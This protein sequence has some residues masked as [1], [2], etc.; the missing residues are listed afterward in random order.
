[1]I[2]DEPLDRLTAARLL[3]K[4]RLRDVAV[5]ALVELWRRHGGPTGKEAAAWVAAALPVHRAALIAQVNGFESYAA[6]WLLANGLTAD[7]P[8]VD[9]DR[10]LE[11]MRSGTPLDEVLHRPV[12]EMR[13]A[14]ASGADPVEAFTRA[15]RRLR[16]IVAT[17]HQQV[18]RLAGHRKWS[19]E[20]AVSGYRR[21]LRGSTNCAL[22]VVASVQRYYSDR[23]MPIHPG[24]DCGVAP[25]VGAVTRAGTIESEL[26]T[27]D[28]AKAALRAEGVRGLG[29]RGTLANLR[30]DADELA[31]IAEANHSE[32][33]PVLKLGR[34][35][36]EAVPFKARAR[37]EFTED[38]RLRVSRGD[39]DYRTEGYADRVAE[40]LDQQ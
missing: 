8:P 31:E 14:L 11:A 27:L 23:L 39:R 1:M 3:A 2:G 19:G 12:V 40:F 15:E 26:P 18:D 9:P 29:S 32:L 5:N 4:T 21:V 38:G 17:D 6:A 35:R 20:R 22:C 36:T 34:H 24:C 25:F 33:G 30:I 37:R 28:A 7:L 16:S 10:V 13:A